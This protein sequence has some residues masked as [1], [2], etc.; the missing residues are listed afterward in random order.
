MKY[1]D[2]KEAILNLLDT[3]ETLTVQQLVEI[4]NSSPADDDLLL[5]A[6]A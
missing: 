4:L 2:R 5:V 3:H 6:S 1:S